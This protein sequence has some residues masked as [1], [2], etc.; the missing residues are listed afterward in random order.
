[1]QFISTN[2]GISRKIV[3]RGLYPAVE[4]PAVTHLDLRIVGAKQYPLPRGS[5]S[6]SA[7]PKDPQDFI[8]ILGTE[9]LSDE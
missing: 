7:A 5:H 9:E 6:H 4:P 8:A 2:S 3:E 1:M